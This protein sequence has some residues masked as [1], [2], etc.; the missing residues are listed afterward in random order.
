MNLDHRFGA[1][2][3]ALRLAPGRTVV[4]VSG[5]PDSLAL[6]LL[7]HRSA[8]S[9]GLELVAAHAD[10]GIHPE[11]G[12][13]AEQ[14]AAWA[15]S[16]GIPLVATRLALGPGAREEAARQARHRWLRSV[17]ASQHA[18]WIM[19]A[20]HREDQVETVL[21]RVLAGSGPAGLA[22]MAPVRGT[23]VRPLLWAS[24]AELGAYA[25]E[26]GWR[27]WEDP[28][29]Q[30]PRN[31]RS[32]IRTMI[33]P[34]LRARDPRVEERVLGLARQAAEARA[35]WEAALDQLPELAPQANRGVVSVAV[36]P[37]QG[38]DSRL[39]S[40]LIQA[41][42]RRA[43]AIVGPAAAERA[44]QLAG[45]GRSGAWVPLGGGW[46][47]ELA[48]GR[49]RIVAPDWPPAA[50]VVPVGRDGEGEIAWGGWRLRW[51]S[52]PGPGRLPRDGWSSWFIP[53]AWELRGWRAG[54]RIHPRG[55]TGS[56]LVVR[57]LQEARVARSDRAGWP[58]LVSPETGT[59]LWVPG[60]CR[61]EH[62]VPAP[63]SEAIRIDVEPG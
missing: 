1:E 54:D 34:Q 42:G 33:L 44:R 38:Y 46:R 9:H 16:L 8:A 7:L 20:H 4:G 25:A 57:C 62:A 53:G 35:G 56:R 13:V 10:H 31:T 24:R 26:S 47:A 51:G 3:A 58:V 5:G 17:R 28:A 63:G 37:L 23:V 49:L 11:S 32:W 45:G 40:A 48:F 29:N 2:L 60:I 21:M 41:L 18:R 52:E 27:P 12:A 14:V 55:G 30:D 15:A 19:L 50:E 22:G 59:L 6:L 39:A 61:A 36:A 43:G